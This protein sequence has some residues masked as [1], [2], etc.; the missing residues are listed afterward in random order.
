MRSECFSMRQ[1]LERSRPGAHDNLANLIAG[2]ANY[3]N[4]RH[5]VTIIGFGLNDGG[6]SLSG[7]NRPPPDAAT[8]TALPTS[9]W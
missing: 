5:T 6:I 8:S 4:I 7:W 9:R 2:L 3:A 1:G